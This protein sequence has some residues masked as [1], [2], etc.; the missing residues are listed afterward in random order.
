MYN[1]KNLILYIDY[2]YRA[3]QHN[4]N[5]YDKFSMAHGV[6]CRFPFLDWRLATYMFSL[7]T[8]S[9]IGNGFTKKILRDS[10]RGILANKVLNRVKKKGFNP[11]NSLFNKTI[12]N[13][14]HDIIYSKDFYQSDIWDGTKIKNFIE[15]NNFRSHSF[16]T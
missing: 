11:S 4:L 10:M 7:P 9:K 12:I 2:H 5:K 13:F 3:M 14:I 16:S 1:Y 6:E 15:K 8:K